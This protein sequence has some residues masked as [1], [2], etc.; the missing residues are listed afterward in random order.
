M[1]DFTLADGKTF[2]GEL[3]LWLQTSGL[4]IV[5]IILGS[6]LLL[7]IIRLLLRRLISRAIR[8]NKQAT[9]FEEKQRETTLTH[10]IFDALRVV[11]WIAAF[12]MVL[13]ELG[14]NI[15]PLLAGAGV[16]GVA[17]GFGGQW[18]IKDLI[19]GLFV[20]LE[21]QY[22][23]GDVV[24]LDGIVGEVEDFDLRATV[25]RDLDGVVHHIPNGAFNRSTNYSMDYS[26][27]NF[28]IGIAYD[29]NIDKAI[30][31]I[32]NTCQELVAE[33][34]FKDLIVEAP[35][36]LRVQ[37]L[38][39]NAVMLKITGKVR[40]MSQWSITGELRKRLKEAFDKAKIE[41]PF[42][43]VDVHQRK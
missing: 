18:L 11:V 20:V 13:S 1:I 43:Q 16:V 22:R 12:M 8:R 25:L 17:L 19:A 24:E 10:T 28:D 32:N 42:P 4:K 15:G 36:F 33:E 38:G 5:I 14:V 31:I 7:R 27:I 3:T 2:L 34:E 40:P 29:A 37:E 26:G 39:D 21:N 23:V 30:K 6:Y 35:A 41:I 9:V